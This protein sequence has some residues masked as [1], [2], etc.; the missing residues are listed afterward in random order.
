VCQLP[1]GTFGGRGGGDDDDDDPRP[2]ML[3]S[4]PALAVRAEVESQPTANGDDGLDNPNVSSSPRTNAPVPM[5]V[6]GGGTDAVVVVVPLA[7]ADSWLLASS[8]CN[9]ASSSAVSWMYAAGGRGKSGGGVSG[10]VEVGTATCPWSR[11]GRFSPCW[12]RFPRRWRGP[13]G[14]M[15]FLLTLRRNGQ[16]WRLLFS[17][18]LRFQ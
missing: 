18:V 7:A 8:S 14:R 2:F 12:G 1:R 6:T 5:V 16:R 15:V 10:G 9:R 17:L 13:W 4:A 11:K 3:T